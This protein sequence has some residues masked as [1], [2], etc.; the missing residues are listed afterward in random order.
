MSDLE[1]LT[2]MTLDWSKEAS[3][4]NYVKSAQDARVV[5]AAGKF[6]P[7]IPLKIIK[8]THMSPNFKTY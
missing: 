7:I 1:H 6:E 8:K 5:A 4:L 2:I 3:P